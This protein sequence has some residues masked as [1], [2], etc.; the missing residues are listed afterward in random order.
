MT[1]YRV[2]IIGFDRE[3]DHFVDLVEVCLTF[4]DINAVGDLLDGVKLVCIVLVSDLT[5]DLLDKILDGQKSRRSAVLIEN[6]SHRLVFFTHI[7]HKLTRVL[8]FVC[9]VCFTHIFRDIERCSGCVLNEDILCPDDTG[10]IVDGLV[11]NGHTRVH[12]LTDHLKKVLVR[13]IV[14]DTDH[15]TGGDHDILRRRIAKINHVID[16]LT[17]IVL[18]DTFLVTYVNDRKELVL[19]NGLFF[20]VLVNPEYK[21]E[22]IRDLLDNKGNG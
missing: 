12:M 15:V 18:K 2:V 10:D 21:E 6:D 13:N 4:D 3:T 14:T 19:R 17:L 22:Q 16:H 9:E 11:V 7:R 1:R 8:E 5:D 20:L